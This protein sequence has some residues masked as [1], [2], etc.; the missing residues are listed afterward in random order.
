MPNGELS[1]KQKRFCEEYILDMN[2]TRAAIRAGYSTKTAR[3]QSA[4]MLRIA[5]IQ[6]YLSELRSEQTKRT[7]INADAVLKELAAVGFSKITDVVD[8]DDDNIVFKKKITN[9]AKASIQSVSVSKAITEQGETR[10]LSVKMHSKISALKELGVHFGLFND[11]NG[12][13]AT[14]K[15]Y[16]TVEPTEDGYVYRAGFSSEADNAS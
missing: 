16:G 8:I 15:Q 11:F 5:K 3:I 4:Q 6:D 12:A 1:S 2:G 9:E 13:I 10:R 14:L 7:Q